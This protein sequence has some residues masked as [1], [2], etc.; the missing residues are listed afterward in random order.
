MLTRP[1]LR[2]DEPSWGSRVPWFAAVLASGWVLVATLALGVLPAVAVWISD[3]ADSAL[4]DPLRFGARIWLVAH[5]IGLDVDGADFV[6]APLGMTVVVMLLMY[7]SARW[8]AHQAGTATPRAIAAVIV[9]AVVVYGAGAS[10][11]ATFATAGDVSSSPLTAGA[12]AAAWALA[13]FSL[14]VL[15]ETGFDEVW[16]ARLSPEVRAALAGGGVAIAGLVL[17]GAALTVAASVLNAGQIGMLADA[18]DAG[19]L[20]TSVL[21][22]GSAAVM[23]NVIVWAAGFSLGPGFA[24]GAETVVAPSGVEL[25]MLPAV[26]V[27]GALPA[28]VPGTFAWLVLA[29]PVAVGV[30][31]GLLVYRRLAQ[32]QE[33]LST[34]VLAAG[35]AGAAAAIGMSVLVTLSSGSI[36]AARLSQVGSV[37]WEV[38]AM[39]F[40]LVGVP[41]TITA[42]VLRWRSTRSSM[43][44][45]DPAHQ[46][47]GNRQ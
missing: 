8:A 9:P 30:L 42:T 11:L 29:G 24:V 44:I 3:G 20:G 26:P 17:V 23:P 45:G 38:A 41:A 4:T 16:L 28:E 2:R 21:A 7:R 34:M 27:L 25:G 18:L 33:P 31:A 32:H 47:V 46:D 19:S 13:G 5:R 14:G 43:I 10:L 36:G 22:A 37:A 12:V 40:L 39:T 35:G 6:F 1:L 15:H